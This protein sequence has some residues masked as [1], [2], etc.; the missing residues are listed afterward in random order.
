[1][2]WQKNKMTRKILVFILFF[3]F[4]PQASFAQVKSFSAQYGNIVGVNELPYPGLL[5]DH[6][7]YFIKM[8]R[9][10]FISFS[11][12]DPVKKAEFDILQADKRL[13][14]GVYLFLEG[15]SKYLLAESTISKG[16][17]Y[18]DEAISKAE[19]AK[20]QGLDVRILRGE[21]LS[22]LSEQ[23]YVL[24]K[25]EDM[26]SGQFKQNLE[27]GS[28]RVSDYEKKTNLVLPSK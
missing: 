9:D 8:I 25:L 22:S 6:P 10:R 4:V 17:N 15:E 26:S 14:A 18:Y 2:Y 28:K 20:K 12:Q 3:F 19:F 11:I 1:M 13:G 23:K 16:E 5:P 24:K 21:I 27:E 7:L